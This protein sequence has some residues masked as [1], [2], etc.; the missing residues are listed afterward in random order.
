MGVWTIVEKG[1]TSNGNGR[2]CRVNVENPAAG[3]RGSHLSQKT[4]KMG[5]L[6]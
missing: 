6:T 4:R 5:T 2:E 3:A 1:G